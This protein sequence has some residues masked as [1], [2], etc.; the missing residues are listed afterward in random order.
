MIVSL[1]V[2][3]SRSPFGKSHA[4]RR[5]SCCSTHTISILFELQSPQ[6]EMRDL[7]N[8]V[9]LHNL[10]YLHKSCFYSELVRIRS[11]SKTIREITY[12]FKKFETSYRAFR[13]ISILRSWTIF[14]KIKLI[15]NRLSKNSFNADR[16]TNFFF[17]FLFVSLTHWVSLTRSSIH[18]P[19]KYLENIKLALKPVEF[20]DFW[21]SE[22]FTGKIIIFFTF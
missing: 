16:F 4:S 3:T 5:S 14:T 12:K 17:F 19:Y 2:L 18:P 9:T 15:F 10:Y 6:S 1:R 20:F 22:Y 8:A 21:V 7:E 11:C 13:T